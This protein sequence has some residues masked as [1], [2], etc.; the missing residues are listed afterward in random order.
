MFLRDAETQGPHQ[1]IPYASSVDHAVEIDISMH[2]PERESESQ[3][4]LLSRSSSPTSAAYTGGCLLVD[5]PD[6]DFV[7]IDRVL[8]NLVCVWISK[9]CLAPPRLLGAIQF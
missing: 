4:T 3:D 5:V 9:D 1:G 6:C 2:V 7:L 8:L